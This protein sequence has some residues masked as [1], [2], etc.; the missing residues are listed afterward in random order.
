MYCLQFKC[1]TPVTKLN[2]IDTSEARKTMPRASMLTL[3][4]TCFP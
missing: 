2:H 3:L 4:S 1:V